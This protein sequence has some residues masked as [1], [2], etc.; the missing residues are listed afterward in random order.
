MM[1]H[2]SLCMYKGALSPGGEP[3]F[4]SEKPAMANRMDQIRISLACVLSLLRQLSTVQDH[5]AQVV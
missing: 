4:R 3:S 2:K 1:F 5:R